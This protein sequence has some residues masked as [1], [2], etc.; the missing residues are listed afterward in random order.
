MPVDGIHSLYKPDVKFKRPIII[1]FKVFRSHSSDGIVLSISLFLPSSV[2][3]IG[4]WLAISGFEPLLIISDNIDCPFQIAKITPYFPKVFDYLIRCLQG[5]L[6]ERQIR[7]HIPDFPVVLVMLLFHCIMLTT[8]L[9]HFPGDKLGKPY[10][11]SNHDECHCCRN[12]KRG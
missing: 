7:I 11:Y 1:I 4:L 10:C 5:S 2:R 12:A 3:E 6:S 9:S 8:K